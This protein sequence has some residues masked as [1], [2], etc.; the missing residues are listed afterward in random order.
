MANELNYKALSGSY[1]LF[2]EFN[3][4]FSD[5]GT[6]GLGWDQ[7]IWGVIVKGAIRFANVQLNQG[8]NPN[9]TFLHIVIGNRYGSQPIYFR[10]WGIKETNTNDFSSYPMSRSK[11]TAYVDGQIDASLNPGDTKSFDISS[12]VNEIVNQAGW[13]PGNA[14]GFIIE[15]NGTTHSSGDQEIFS[16]YSLISVR[17]NAEPNFL[18]TPKSV[19]APT[20]PSS[21]DYGARFS[22][23]GVNV[24]EATEDQL[25]FTSK[26]LALKIS[27]ERQVACTA[28]SD[29]SIAHGLSYKPLCMV[30]AR[31]NGKSFKLTRYFEGTDPAGADG[32]LGYFRVTSTH[33][34]ITVSKSV[35][36]Y[37]YITLEE[38]S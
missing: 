34:I 15:D 35:N 14:M 4:M 36:V 26:K 38:E 6:F 22:M 21:S 13:S 29:T 37:Y 20:F 33:L 9:L 16:S 25:F 2:Y 12:V 11:T 7:S 18:P 1:N 32:V 30:Y 5:Y 19:S 23:P 8:V 28:G 31:N 27:A 3:G 10:L 24:L 17:Q